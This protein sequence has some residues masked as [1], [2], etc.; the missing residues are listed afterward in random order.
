M[1]TPVAVLVIVT[2]AS[3][4]AAPE[5]SSTVPL[6]SP[7]FAFWADA[8]WLS[9]IAKSSKQNGTYGQRALAFIREDLLVM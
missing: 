6:I 5:E 7:V 3:A 1:L 9:I 8:N 2:F 4:T